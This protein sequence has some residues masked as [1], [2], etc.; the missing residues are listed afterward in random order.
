M[1]YT[2]FLLLFLVAFQVDALDD[3]EV[4]INDAAELR[5]WCRE[6]SE[7]EFVAKN[8]TP[9]NWSASWWQEGNMLLVEGYWRVGGD[10][11]IVTCRVAKGAR[12]KYAVYDI[13]VRE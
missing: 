10:E 1:K 2:I 8:I 11:V 5:D 12:R 6:E 7:A 3:E 4:P 9:Y 13:K